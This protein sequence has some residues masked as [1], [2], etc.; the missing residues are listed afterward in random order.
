MFHDCDGDG[1]DDLMVGEPYY[2]VTTGG[3]EARVCVYSSATFALIRT[4][5]GTRNVEWFG[6]TIS[7][8]GDV[9]LDGYSDYVVGSRN[10][11]S[12]G[13]TYNGEVVV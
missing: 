5:D 8:A 13:L 11:S 4:H 2:N 7:G 6:F 1:V 12:N 3:F 10:H 9:N